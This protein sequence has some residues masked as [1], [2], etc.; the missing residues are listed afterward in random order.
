MALTEHNNIS[1]AQIILFVPFLAVGIVLCI[2]HGFRRNTGWLLLV[3][4]SIARIL[5]AALQLATISNPK[6]LSLYF[7]A[8]TLQSIGLSPL[9]IMLLALIN[10]ALESIEKARS[11]IINPR[12]LRLVQLLVLVGLILSSIGGSDSGDN[13]AK[14]GTYTVSPLTRAGVALVIV[15]F[16]LLVIATVVVGINVSY[17]EPGEK[18]VVLAVALSLPF[19]LVR[20]IYSA[21]NAFGN[22]P[23]FGQVTGDI[24]ILLGTAVIEE[25]IIVFIVEVMG[26]T[27]QVRPKRED[28]YEMRSLNRHSDGSAL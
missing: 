24:N 17:A 10:R 16:A 7:G 23:A 5:G 4:F 21:V 1:I 2:R 15:G 6:N 25:I 20:I 11:A 9:L 13:Y 3:V 18:R 27:L 14:T 19:L 28:G 8:L 12:V 26:L 22:N